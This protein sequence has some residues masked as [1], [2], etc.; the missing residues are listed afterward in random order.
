[1]NV[2]FRV[3]ASVKIGSGHFVR[4]LTLADRLKDS[5][6][7][8]CFF[9]RQLPDHMRLS[10]EASGHGFQ[11]LD[12]DQG[13][14]VMDEDLPHSSWL[15]TS[16]R[17]DAMNSIRALSSARWDWLVVD[18][19]ALDTR[20]ERRLRSCA[21]RILVI[22]D[23]ADRSHDC[24][25][26]LDQ[27]LVHHMAMRYEGKTD[28]ECRLLLGPKYALLQEDYALFH[29]TTL[30]RVGP[31][32]RI[33]VFFGGS[34]IDNFTGRSL[35]AF[36]ALDCREIQLDVVISVDCP[37]AVTIRNQISGRENIHIHSGLQSLAPLMAEADLAIG[38]A[39]ATTWERLC[40]GLP[41]LVITLADNQKPIASELEKQGLAVVLGN[42]SGVGEDVIRRHLGPIIRNGLK[43]AW[44]EHCRMFVDG[45][46]ADRVVGVL[47]EVSVAAAING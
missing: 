17:F 13:K 33:L 10:L 28:P 5:G 36:I 35:A 45:C 43:P 14:G 44:S 9:S 20:W 37:H 12:E 21:G 40:L 3:D 47:N 15:G 39:G 7:S 34:D 6:C 41:S 18:H 16:Q 19:Y 22:D 29:N 23:L 8:T 27:N 2:A 30:P 32:K 38:A 26:L 4:C 31:V 25:V 11:L 42:K 24:D 1:M 46:G